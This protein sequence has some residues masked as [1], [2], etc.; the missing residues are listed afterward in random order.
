NNDDP[1]GLDELDELLSKCREGAGTGGMTAD[2]SLRAFLSESDDQQQ[3]A[4]DCRTGCHPGTKSSVP[5]FNPVFAPTSKLEQIAKGGL[6]YS[7]KCGWIDWSH[8]GG[9]K[10]QESAFHEVW[11]KIQEQGSKATGPNEKICYEQTQQKNTFLG[12]VQTGY[13]RCFYVSTGMNLKQMQ[14]AAWYI[15]KR[16]NEEF[17]QHQSQMWIYNESGF[18]PEDLSSDLILFHRIVYGIS[19]D[20]IKELCGPIITDTERLRELAEEFSWEEQNRAWA[21][22]PCPAALRDCGD[23]TP[24]LPTQMPPTLRPPY[25]DSPFDCSSFEGVWYGPLHG[26][27]IF[28]RL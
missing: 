14:C 15:F 8:A 9:D 24:G 18:S 26:E 12:K 4:V 11:R 7:C 13:R 23:E 17:E 21:P 27:T 22:K 20:R 10:F 1:S 2:E 19:L 6:Q 16:V 5:R 3:C 25:Q 28:R